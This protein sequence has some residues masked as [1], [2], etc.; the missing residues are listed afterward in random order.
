[1]SKPK[2]VIYAYSFN[3]NVGG[4]IVLHHLCHLLNR[5][6]ENAF[7]WPISRTDVFYGKKYWPAIN[8][9]FTL[10]K[11]VFRREFKT[12]QN[13]ETPIASIEDLTDA[14]VIYPE[15]IFGNPL[16]A[17]KIVRWFLNKPG[18]FS[19]KT[20]YGSN[21]L[22]FYYGQHF[23][24]RSLNGGAKKQLKTLYI[25]DDIYQHY[26][27]GLRQASCY[28]LR[29]GKGRRLVHDSENSILI[30]ALT[31][32]EIAKVFN[33]VKYCIS[34]DAYTMLSKY[35]AICGCISVVIPEDGVSK[36]EWR[37]NVEDRYGIAYGFD[38]LDWAIETQSLVLQNFKDQEI[39][40]M[41]QVNEF[42][43]DTKKYFANNV[44]DDRD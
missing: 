42:I 44:E 24:D 28:I 43:E 36:E 23:N 34:Y 3:E 31:H 10:L 9:A 38:D 27:R 4:V 17:G 18:I 19:G 14:I 26:N 21:E 5:M 15:V 37:P 41:E 39:R 2:Y 12:S 1:M 6:G 40:M 25:R 16:G 13:F 11:K 35:A 8:G 33:Q 20:N 7:L 30:D 22:Y 29:K 32:E